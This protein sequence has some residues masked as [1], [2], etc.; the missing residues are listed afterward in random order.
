[1]RFGKTFLAI[2]ALALALTGLSGPSRAANILF[3]FVGTQYY[4]NGTGLSNFLS[5]AGHSVTN[6]NLYNTSLG[7]LAGYDQ[8]WVYD[9]NTG[10]D[11]TSTL[12][13]NYAT[14]AN[15][16]DATQH[17]LIVDGRIISSNYT[18]RSEPDWIRNYAARLGTVGS[19]NGGLVLGTDHDVFTNGINTINALLGI[20][21][22]IGN[23]YQPPY[24]AKVD[25]QSPLY[26]ASN[27]GT[28][29]CSDGSGD[30]CIWDHSSTSYVPT[31][32]FTL[33]SGHTIT[34]TP[35]AYHGHTSDAWDNAAVASTFGS[36]TF[37]TCGGPGQPACENEI[38]APLP[39]PMLGLGLAA[40]AALRHLREA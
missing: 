3:G 15:W 8:V 40:L 36:R 9:L 10:S 16:F 2:G 12:N 14:I 24:E 28:H 30:R 6:V 13:A 20:D 26:N 18:T 35:T 38:P 5:T 39:W 11:S 1:M 17:D 25:E 23:F 32:T 37:G 33:T 27:G 34:L 29:A 19:G 21:P 31:G 22:F 4:S 7:S